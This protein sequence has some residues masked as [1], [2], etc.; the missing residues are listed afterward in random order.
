MA[1]LTAVPS[2]WVS[3]D[4]S[5]LLLSELFKLSDGTGEGASSNLARAIIVGGIT[6]KELIRLMTVCRKTGMKPPLWA[7]LTPVSEKWTL[8]ALLSELSAERRALRKKR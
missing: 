1:G 5:D 7:T 2:V 3:R 4:R 6:E 8:Q